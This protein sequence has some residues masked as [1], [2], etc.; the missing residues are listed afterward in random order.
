MSASARCHA[1][2]MKTQLN[3]GVPGGREVENFEEEES[4]CPKKCIA[5]R[6]GEGP[7]TGCGQRF[8][9]LRD[10]CQITP[11]K[12]HHLPVTEM[13]HSCQAKTRAV[14]QLYINGTTISFWKNDI[15]MGTR[16]ELLEEE[17]TPEKIRKTNCE[18]SSRKE[19]TGLGNQ[20]C[21]HVGCVKSL[22]IGRPQRREDVNSLGRCRGQQQGVLWDHLSGA[23]QQRGLLSC[24]W[25]MEPCMCV[26]LAPVG[27]PICRVFSLTYLIKKRIF[28]PNCDCSLLLPQLGQPSV[29]HLSPLLSGPMLRA[30]C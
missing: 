8:R 13:A 27:R 3:V 10:R 2:E 12:V 11:G 23:C 25:H 24:L 16:G 26:C 7:S 28:L 6:L 1:V 22:E 15:E 30:A 19:P 18:H 17:T 14:L 5:T 21:E 20:K 4:L 9:I 29:P